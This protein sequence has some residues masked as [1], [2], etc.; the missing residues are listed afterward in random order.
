MRLQAYSLFNSDPDQEWL[1]KL[2][3]TCL[4]SQWNRECLHELYE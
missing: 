3:A 2:D 1:E 4:D